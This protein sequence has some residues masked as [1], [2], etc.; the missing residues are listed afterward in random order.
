MLRNAAIWLV[1][2]MSAWSLSAQST[3]ASGAGDIRLL[4]GYVNTRV[5]P[6]DSAEAGRISKP[7]GLLISYDIGLAAG[8][9]KL[10]PL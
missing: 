1:L 9:M 8:P 3:Q 7:D 10:I 4:P 5:R 2:I 6:I